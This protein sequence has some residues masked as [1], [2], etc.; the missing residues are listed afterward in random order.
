MRKVSAEPIDPETDAFVANVD[1]AF[2]EEVFNIPK[3][4]RKP[5]IHED[6]KLNDLGRC[7]KVAEGVLIIFRG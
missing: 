2:M 4:E 6:G 7:F 5:D 1:A 3:R